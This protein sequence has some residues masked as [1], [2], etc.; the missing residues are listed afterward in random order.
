MIEGCLPIP[1]I[2]DLEALLNL[3]LPVEPQWGTLMQPAI[4]LSVM[5][6]EVR[7]PG[8]S[9]DVEDAENAARSAKKIRNAVRFA[10]TLS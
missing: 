6:I 9:A 1:R 3:L 4:T 7:Y 2:H 10:L 8:M 5:A